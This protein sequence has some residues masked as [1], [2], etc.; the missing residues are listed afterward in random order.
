MKESPS[1]RVARNISRTEVLKVIRAEG[2]IS[3]SKLAE[4]VPVSRA[5][6]SSI[7]S[8][9]L[10][11]GVLEEVGE[12][13]STG[14]RR[15]VRLRYRPESRIA[16]GLVLF[17]NKIQA[18]LT[19]MEG[20]PL[21]D[22]LEI[23]LR[24]AESEFMLQSM[25]ETAERLLEGI[26]RDHVLGVGV[27]VPGI[28][29]F[30]TGVIE[31]SVSKGWLEGG[32]KVKEYLEDALGL[33]VYVANRSR[34]AVLGEHRVGK[35]CD[36]SN[37]I[38]L[39]LGQGIAAGIVIDGSL[40]LGPGSSA[41]EIGHV[42]VVPDGPLCGCGNRGC[43]EVYATEAAILARAR[44]LARED[45]RSFL[46]QTVDNHLERLTIDHV[47]QAAKQGDTTA[48]AVLTDAGTKV[49]IAVSSL[50]DLFNPE[51]VIIGGPIGYSAGQV[52]LDPIIKEAQRR[53]L[54]RS[55]QMAT[56]INGTLGTKA[57]AIG[58]AVLAINHTP[59]DTIF[60]AWLRGKEVSAPASRL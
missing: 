59:V 35:C 47:I 18:V 14:G 7:V 51:M 2:C 21:G 24:G 27:G 20:N 4:M 26:P 5:T 53:T 39:F 56:I 6:V 55:F 9:L 43:L 37:L 57:V 17:D 38:Y 46:Q 31:I 58:A 12:G 40:Y 50:I 42:S 41:G 45:P 3:R 28:V 23:P 36:V 33:P 48:L 16:M 11:T 32:I 13:Q 44:A 34:V 29:D 10:E 25:Q 60:G 8:E 54:P 15:P 52:L 49:G 1:T 30:E 22:Y 19:D